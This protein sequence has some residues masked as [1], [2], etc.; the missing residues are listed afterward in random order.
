MT[1][2]DINHGQCHYDLQYI[3]LQNKFTVQQ[4]HIFHIYNCLL[5]SA[6]LRFVP[7]ESFQSQASTAAF[8]VLRTMSLICSCMMTHLSWPVVSLAQV[9]KRSADH[10]ASKS[11]SKMKHLETQIAGGCAFSDQTNIVRDLSD[12]G[13]LAAGL[14]DL[15]KIRCRSLKSSG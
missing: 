5:P 8:K 1:G 14:S 7:I 12:H 15:W 13:P 9:A 4:S 10:L 2:K 3:L 11:F 6:A